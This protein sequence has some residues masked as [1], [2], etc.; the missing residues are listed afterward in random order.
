MREELKGI[1]DVKDVKLMNLE[2]GEV[3]LE[4]DTLKV[5][6]VESEEELEYEKDI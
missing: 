6:K 4:F 3:L 2:T 1:E 5:S